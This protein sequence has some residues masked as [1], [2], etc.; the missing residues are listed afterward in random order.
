MREFL[1]RGQDGSLAFSRRDALKA[2]VLAL[3]A[4]VTGCAKSST[5]LRWWS[6]QSS[7][8]QVAAY[9]YQIEAFEASHPGVEVRFERLSDEGYGAQ[10][11]AAFAGGNVPN[12]VTH[13]PSFA[14]ADYWQ[15]GLLQ[16]AG[17]LITAVGKDRFIDGANRIYQTDDGLHAATCLGNTAANMLWLRKDLMEKAGIDTPPRTWDELRT[18]AARMQG[19]GIYGAPLPYARNSM[20]TLVIIGFIHQAG[21][22]IFSPDLDVAIVSDATIDALEFYRSMREYCPPG[23]T[24]YSWGESL[25]AFVSGATATGL[26]SGRVLINV[27]QQNPQLADQVTC[28]PYPTISV[29]IAPWTYND[30]PS[31]FVPTAAQNPELSLALAASLYEPTGYIRQMNATPGHV[32]PVL[33]DVDNDPAYLSN[34]LV[35]KYSQEIDFMGQA[36]AAGHNLGRET[37]AHRSNSRAGAIVQSGVLAEMVQR[38]VLNDEVPRLVLQD[39]AAKIEQLM[40]A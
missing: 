2:G 11:A 3:A 26:Y 14:V 30:F 29:D 23:A 19:D 12:V 38:V 16:P 18:A 8:A 4:A 32:L 24:N 5:V 37:T 21:G 35:R 39:T 13:L 1:Q 27:G 28:V 17:G 7:P 9:E 36:A 6:T 33:K 31:V 15:A 40:R 22:S 20:T 10:L 34:E 25:T